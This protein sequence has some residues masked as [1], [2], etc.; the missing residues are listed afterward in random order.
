MYHFTTGHSR[1]LSTGAFIPD[2]VVTS[3]ELMR[4]IDSL[5]RFGIPYDWMDKKMGILERRVADASDMPSD[6]AAR[7]A[8]EAIDLA[9]INP[10]EID[11]IIYAGIDRD[12]VE[13]A[14]AHLVQDK[15]GASNAYCVDVSNACHGFM[16]GIHLMDALVTSGQVRYGLICT[17]EQPSKIARQ[18][19]AKLKQA[20]T[21]DEFYR[22]VG[23]LSTGDAGAA[24]IIGP[25]RQPESGFIG[26]M[27][28]SQGRH[29]DLCVYSNR[30]GEPDGHM[31]MRDIVRAFIDMHAKMFQQCL[32]ELHWKPEDIDLFVHHQ[33]GIKVFKKHAAYAHIPVDIMPNTVSKMGNITSATIPINIYNL[34]QARSL[35]DNDKIFLSGTGSGLS[36]S[37]TG[38]IWEAA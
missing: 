15:I 21:R 26:F 16:N 35:K 1:I 2:Q 31:H 17:G 29:N 7:A 12:Y 30:F 22:L 3:Q 38:L 37:Q 28:E 14:T 9:G 10:R 8:R 18:T 6:M 34:M 24:M 20:T 4:E 11:A 25:K 27:L 5:N 33:V 23:G 36:I 19:I 13:P 32:H